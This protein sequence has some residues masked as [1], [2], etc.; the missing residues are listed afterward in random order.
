MRGRFAS[1]RRRP[2]PALRLEPVVTLAL[3]A[4]AL[5]APWPRLAVAG[6]KPA[7]DAR[8]DF[9]YIA[10]NEGDGSA[11]HVAVAFGDRSTGRR[12]ATS[13]T[14]TPSAATARSVA[15]TSR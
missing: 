2:T 3:V 6:T 14:A 15:C 11:G 9:L 12:R 10:A 1:A 7:F 4:L 5:V 13:A 8:F